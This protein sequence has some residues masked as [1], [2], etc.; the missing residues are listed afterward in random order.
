MPACH[1]KYFQALFY[2]SVF[3]AG[4]PLVAGSFT[5]TTTADSGVGSLRQAIIDANVTGGPGSTITFTVPGTIN[6]ASS[7]PPIGPDITTIDTGGNAV[8][9][10]GSNLYQAF[11]VVPGATSL[12]IGSNLSLSQVASVG[13]SGGSGLGDGGGGALGAG[14]GVFVGTGTTVDIAGLSFANCSA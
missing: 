8:T 2:F 6:L 1:R 9:I 11:F 12:S 5:V 7:L 3:S 4:V 14:A 13:G 10:N